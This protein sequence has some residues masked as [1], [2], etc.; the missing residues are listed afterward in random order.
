MAQQFWRHIDTTLEKFKHTQCPLC[1]ILGEDRMT[2]CRDPNGVLKVWLERENCIHAATDS[3]LQTR[4]QVFKSDIQKIVYGWT[5]NSIELVTFQLKIAKH[6]I[7]KNLEN[8][9]GSQIWR[10]GALELN[11]NNALKRLIRPQVLKSDKKKW[12]TAA[13]HSIEF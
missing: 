4:F 3:H 1:H 6:L 7:D 5:G 13:Q 9:T 10:G 2:L 12:C 11:L 8:K